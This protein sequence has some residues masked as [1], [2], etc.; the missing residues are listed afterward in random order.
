MLHFNNAGCSLPPAE[1]N[2]AGVFYISSV[3]TNVSCG[4]IPS[5]NTYQVLQFVSTS[6]WKPRSVAMKR[7]NCAIPTR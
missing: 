3:L 6:S 4:E 2:T 5:V 1:V 7:L